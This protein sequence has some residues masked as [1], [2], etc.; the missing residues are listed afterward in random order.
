MAP[1]DILTFWFEDAGPD[2]WYRKSDAFDSEIRARFEH[3]AIDQ[4]AR[5]QM[6]KTHKWEE[7]P[8]STLALIILTDQ[9]SRNMYRGTVAAF[10]WD[11]LALA[12]ATRMVDKGWDLKIDMG[13]RA[14]IYMPFMHSEDPDMQARCVYLADSRL[15]DGSTLHH[16]RE[17][18]KVIAR[19]GRFP[20][21]NDILGRESTLEEIAF[22]DSGGYAP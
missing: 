15:E 11:D 5:L 14:F 1:D 21:R 18:E 9:F 13:R 17:H 3:F 7:V 20:H 19:F 6:T 16:A 4:V 8:E 12:V 22:L 10:A 2:R